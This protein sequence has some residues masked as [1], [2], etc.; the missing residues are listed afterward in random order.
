MQEE[1]T[2][3]TLADE[4][5]DVQV[6]FNHFQSLVACVEL[7]VRLDLEEAHA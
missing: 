7:K 5:N 4:Q 3:V 6:L 2:L 1:A